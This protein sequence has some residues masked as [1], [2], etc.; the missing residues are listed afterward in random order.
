MLTSTQ[1]LDEYIQIW[2]EKRDAGI[3]HTREAWDERADEWVKEEQNEQ[4]SRMTQ[5]RI[6]ESIKV[7]QGAGALGPD[8][9][10][11]DVGC[12][13][14]HFVAEFARTAK[15]VTGTDLSP[16]MLEHGADY[17]HQRGL[18]NT[19]FVPCDFKEISVEEM[20]WR[21]AFDL[22]F[23]SMTPA[24][25]EFRCIEKI[26]EMSR[27]WCCNSTCIISSST[28][29]T[30]LAGILGIEAVR[31]A[32]DGRWFHALN[33]IVWLLGYF[34]QT[35][36]YE[37]RYEENYEITQKTVERLLRHHYRELTPGED[38]AQEVY[39]RLLE[40][41]D[42]GIFTDQIVSWHGSVLWDTRIRTRRW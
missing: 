18:Y 12:G 24:L 40:K 34:P 42:N 21:G 37:L 9:N 17:C 28:M 13:P 8:S 32:W 11:I 7:L 30:E 23:S 26:I 20:G 22:V 19:S 5:R 3:A 33:S 31:P 6:A 41:A 27:G 16:R 39:E 10:V 14:C 35:S 15:H 1:L 4:D 38:R 29:E 25:S 36:Y 2:E